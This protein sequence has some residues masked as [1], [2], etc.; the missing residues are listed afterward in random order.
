MFIFYVVFIF[1]LCF[2]FPSMFIDLTFEAALILG[3][4]SSQASV[5]ANSCEVHKRRQREYEWSLFL[6]VGEAGVR[7]EISFVSEC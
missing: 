4:I 1:I 2:A 3:A 6:K 5:A 7:S